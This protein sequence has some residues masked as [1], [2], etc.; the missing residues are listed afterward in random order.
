MKTLISIEGGDS[1]GKATQAVFL[2]ARLQSMGISAI[3]FEIPA[4]GPITRPLIY[5]MLYVNLAGKFPRVFHTLQFLNK[6]LF[7]FFVLRLVSLFYDCVILDR[8]HGSY[9]V[10]GIESGLD[11][12]ST[13]MKMSSLLK[14]PDLIFCL[15]G[16][17]HVVE[18]R[19]E[20]ERNDDMQSRVARS[21]VEWA[22]AKNNCHIVNSDRD[23]LSVHQDI[24][25]VV[26]EKTNL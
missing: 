17:R 24:W 23:K 12:T 3:N 11:R 19:D 8:W 15:S 6:F 5:F 18:R 25:N 1:T 13:L 21:Y 22:R 4:H 14:E 16:P 20:Y 26:S 2:E 10:Y 7:Q 9:W